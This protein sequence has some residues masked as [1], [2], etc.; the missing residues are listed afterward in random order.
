MMDVFFFGAVCVFLGCSLYMLSFFMSFCSNPHW[1][2]F[3][4]TG[5][6]TTILGSSTLLALFV[7]WAVTQGLPMLLTLC[8]VL[9]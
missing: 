2:F 9:W 7:W 4:K 8:L 3:C 1:G 5:I 6:W